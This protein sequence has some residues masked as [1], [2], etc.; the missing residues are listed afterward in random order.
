MIVDTSVLIAF[1]K[2]IKSR[3]TQILKEYEASNIPYFIPLICAQE[4]LQGALNEKEWLT[5]KEYLFSQNLIIPANPLETHLKAA[6]IYYDCRRKGI[7]IRSTLDCL[8]AQ[9]CIE[10]K[11]PLLHQDRDFD[12]L[13]SVCKLKVVGAP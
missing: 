5:L 2:G 9:I 12:A 13:A 3:Q 7:T 10:L 1:F 6:R 8:I 11:D 4:V